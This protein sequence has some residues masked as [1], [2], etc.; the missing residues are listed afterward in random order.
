MDIIV[1]A[2]NGYLA[3]PFDVVTLADRLTEVLTFSEDRWR[4][5]SDAGPTTRPGVTPGTWPRI[6]SRLVFK[7]PSSGTAR[8]D[9]GGHAQ[10]GPAR[11]PVVSGVGGPG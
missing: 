5:M 6:A 7:S 3:D 1:D 4:M 8:G 9:F 11:D 2:Q 10:P